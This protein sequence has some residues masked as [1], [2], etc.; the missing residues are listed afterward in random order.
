MIFRRQFGNNVELIL[1]IYIDDIP[2]TISRGIM[3]VI[4]DGI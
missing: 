4:N 3:S 2:V 1:E